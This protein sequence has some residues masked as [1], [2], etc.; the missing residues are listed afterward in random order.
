MW[1]HHCPLHSLPGRLKNIQKSLAVHAYATILESEQWFS[2]ALPSMSKEIVPA[3]GA[4]H[5]Y[6]KALVAIGGTGTKR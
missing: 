5:I 4:L 6:A 1:T 3:F 2:N